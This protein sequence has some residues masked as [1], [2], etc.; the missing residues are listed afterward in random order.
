M[1]G[2]SSSLTSPASSSLI[3]NAPTDVMADAHDQRDLGADRNT[4]QGDRVFVAL[5]FESAIIPD[6]VQIGA[7]LVQRCHRAQD[8]MAS[9]PRIGRR[10][11]QVA[12]P[13]V[14]TETVRVATSV[15]PT[16]ARTRKTAEEVGACTTLWAR[17]V[18][19]VT[20]VAASRK[21]SN[22]EVARV[23]DQRETRPNETLAAGRGR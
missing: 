14:L 1:T 18:S 9:H 11:D 12:K 16:L 4:A 8:P 17:P 22:A 6:V 21:P 7:G 3:G 13:S 5:G 23:G 20:T 2:T 19:S 10:G 15:S